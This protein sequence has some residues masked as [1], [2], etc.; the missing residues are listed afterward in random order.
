VYRLL[1]KDDVRKDIVDEDVYLLWPDTNTWYKAFV[2]KVRAGPTW[3]AAGCCTTPAAE[4][5]LPGC[6][7][8]AAWVHPACAGSRPRSCS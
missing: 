5:H 6:T 3:H 8:G 7:L 1:G 4:L 2:S